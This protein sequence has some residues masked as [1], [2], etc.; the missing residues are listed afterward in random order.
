MQY[1]VSLVLKKEKVNTDGTVTITNNLELF[2]ASS[3]NEAVGMS[4]E[5][6]KERE[7]LINHVLIC[8]SA[9]LM[10]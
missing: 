4:I 9:I 2:E 1:A 7:E 10:K 6:W 5:K 8:A 3:A